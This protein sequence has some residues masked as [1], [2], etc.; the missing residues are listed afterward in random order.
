MDGYDADDKTKVEEQINEAYNQLLAFTYLENSDKTKYGSL[1][2]G[3]PAQHSLKNSQYPQTITEAT[4]ILSN[5]RFDTVGKNDN[6]K[7]SNNSEKDKQQ[8][9]RR[10][11]KCPIQCLKGSVIVV[12]KS[13]TISNVS[14]KGYNSKRRMGNQQGQSKRTISC[15]CT[16]YT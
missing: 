8:K 14:I 11:P 15:Q 3:L 1:L 10:N 7:S 9:M 16:V 5:R 13:D 12:V 4:N 2:S 6:K